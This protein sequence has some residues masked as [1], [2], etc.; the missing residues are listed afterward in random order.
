MEND[1]NRRISKIHTAAMQGTY[2]FTVH[3]FARIRERNITV[4]EIDQ[5]L[6]SAE[7]IEHYRDRAFGEACLVLG[8]TEAGRVLHVVCGIEHGVTVISAYE[9]DPA[10]W[11]EDFTTRRSR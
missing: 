5:A 10:E 6:L 3:G 2:V 11:E 1:H 7:L 9:P 4:A 8:R